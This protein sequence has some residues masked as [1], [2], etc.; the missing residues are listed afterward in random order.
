MIMPPNMFILFD[1]FWDSAV[2]A[3]K[4]KGYLLIWHAAVWAIWKA[5]NNI[6][7]NHG[8]MVVSQVVD[9]IKAISW[10]WS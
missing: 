10:R 4:R 8:A 2:G 3:Q 6:I 5:R 1:C 9:E 7:F